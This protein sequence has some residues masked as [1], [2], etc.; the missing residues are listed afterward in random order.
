MLKSIIALSVNVLPN[1]RIFS[2]A[3]TNIFIAM[4]INTFKLNVAVI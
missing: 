3:N 4:P 2:E 1:A